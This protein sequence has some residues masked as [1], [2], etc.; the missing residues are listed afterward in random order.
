M[1][2]RIP[3]KGGD[4]YD[5]FSPWRR[6]LCYLGRPGVV[7]KIKRGYKKRERKQAK[8]AVN[9]RARRTDVNH[10]AIR[11]ALRDIPGVTVADTSG[12]GM[13]FPDL[14]VGYLGRN[15]LFEIKAD[16]KKRLTPRQVDFFDTWAGDVRVITCIDDALDAMRV[17]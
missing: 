11:S 4:E 9:M 2:G 3:M 8:Q 15:F 17:R 14:V 1:K 6:L 13:G 5:A 7:K 10:A 12:A 16:H